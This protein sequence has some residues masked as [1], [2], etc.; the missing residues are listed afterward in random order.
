M[1]AG[2]RLLGVLLA[3]WLPAGDV[4]GGLEFQERMRFYRPGEAATF[5]GFYR[6]VMGAVEAGD[7]ARLA[8]LV[9]FP[10]RVRV[11]GRPVTVRDR[12]AFIRVG[13]QVL[14]EPFRA[15]LLGERDDLRLLSGGVSLG[16]GDL[17]FNT[18]P[19]GVWRVIAINN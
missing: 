13:R 4:P 18:V 11:R 6:E 3:V 8:R 15:H 2:S 10:A 7:P 1:R 17:W 14:G 9:R 5:A 16:R 19:A 12:A